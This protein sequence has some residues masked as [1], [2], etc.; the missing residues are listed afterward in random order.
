MYPNVGAYWGLEDVRVHDPMAFDRYVRYLEQNAGWNRADYYAKWSDAQ[1]PLLDRLNVRYIVS[2]REL[3]GRPLVYAGRDGFIYENP[4]AR[5]RFFSDSAEVTVDGS[6]VRVKAA[7]HALVK[8]SVPAYP[9]WTANVK[10]FES[11][12]PFLAFMVPPGEHV[13]ELQYRPRSFDLSL[14]VAAIA[15]VALLVRTRRR[16]APR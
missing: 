14:I 13:V 5:G 1:S 11:D 7:Q 10:L 4:T 2:D 12:G 3:P 9:G 15:T 6:R 8:S 16:R